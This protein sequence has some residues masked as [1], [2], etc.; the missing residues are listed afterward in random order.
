MMKILQ[1]GLALRK[2]GFK[3]DSCAHGCGDSIVIVLISFPPV[4][5]AHE[6]WPIL[7]TCSPVM[8][9]EQ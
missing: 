9:N 2:L 7:A 1:V 5:G 6:Q 8:L 3:Q 4:L